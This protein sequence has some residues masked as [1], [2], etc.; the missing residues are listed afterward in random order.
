MRSAGETGP[1]LRSLAYGR[2][3]YKG[4]RKG[5]GKGKPPVDASIQYRYAAVVDHVRGLTVARVQ[6]AL[7]R[8]ALE[9]LRPHFQAADVKG[10]TAMVEVGWSF[11]A[12]DR[13][14]KMQAAKTPQNFPALLALLQSAM[15][16]LSGVDDLGEE[17]LNVICRQYVQGQ[18]LPKHVDRPRMFQEEVYGCVLLNTSDQVLEF[19]KTDRDTGQRLCLHRVA[20]NCGACFCQEGEARYQWSHGVEPLTEGERVSVTWR[21]F[22]DG[23]RQPL[24]VPTVNQIPGG[25][26]R[27]DLPGAEVLYIRNC[28]SAEESTGLFQELDSHPSWAKR[29]VRVRNRETGDYFDTLE[30][31][32]TISFSSPPGREYSYSGSF[33]TAEAFPECALA[34]KARIEDLLKVPMTK[35]A[36]AVGLKACFN[37]CLVNKYEDG[38][39]GV[40]KHSD[41]EHDIVKCSPIACLSLGATRKFL[42]ESKADPECSAALSLEA[43]SLLLMLGRTQQNYVHTVPKEA[44]VKQPRI[45]LTFRVNVDVDCP[46][47]TE[48]ASVR[49]AAWRG[50]KTDAGAAATTGE[51][52]PSEQSVGEP[53]IDKTNQPCSRRWRRRSETTRG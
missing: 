4:T 17:T 28:L 9:E 46:S 49:R 33:R 31:R 23:S 1:I 27:L 20:E 51:T 5:R 21:W 37:Y 10:A 25:P 53:D 34:A 19:E 16:A 48:T 30:G 8:R 39:Q 29:P 22:H 26:E 18:G 40:G 24:A 50:M 36:A 47:A 13:S 35:W 43:G 32:P 38:Y 45:S 52:A 2:E 42:F 11:L 15:L 44:R 41:D 3:A 14:E 12:M 7:A 6:E